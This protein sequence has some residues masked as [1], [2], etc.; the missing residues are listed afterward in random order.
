MTKDMMVKTLSEY[1]T[2]KGGVMDLVEYKSQG[3]DVPIKDYIVR[4]SFGSWNRVL[5]VVSKRYPVSVAPVEVAKPKAA[6]KPKA[7]VKVESKDG[8]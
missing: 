3:N 8:E 5:S 2:K 4:K 7:E 1:F 6:P